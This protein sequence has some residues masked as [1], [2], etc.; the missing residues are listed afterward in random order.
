MYMGVYVY[1]C[2]CMGVCMGICIHGYLCVCMCGMV[3]VYMGVCVYEC[4]CMG[5]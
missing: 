1:E 2:M 4:M 3:F 5:V